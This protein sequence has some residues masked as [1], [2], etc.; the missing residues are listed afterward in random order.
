MA[1]RVRSPTQ[2]SRILSSG[3]HKAKIGLP[4]GCLLIWK[5]NLGAVRVVH[6]MHFL[7][8]YGCG[9]HFL[10][11]LDAVSQLPESRLRPLP[12]RFLSD[13]AVCL[14]QASRNTWLYNSLP[15]LKS[16]PDGGRAIQ[17]HV[18]FDQFRGIDWEPYY[19]CKI[20]HNDKVFSDSRGVSWCTGNV[21]QGVEY[22]G[23]F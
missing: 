13:M 7:L 9:P 14:F 12:W 3:S 23:W 20:H 5:L 16:S 11:S 21:H 4:A 17:E 22:W 10:A 6:R 2:F 15:V 18:S 19:V 8:M 1:P